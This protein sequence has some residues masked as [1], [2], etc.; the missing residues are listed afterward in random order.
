MSARPVHVRV[1]TLSGIAVCENCG[2][3]TSF[4]RPL[5]EDELERIRCA[6]CRSPAVELW[7]GSF[8]ATLEIVEAGKEGS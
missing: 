4:D 1:K 6:G 7:R 3:W 5:E 8:W 2:A